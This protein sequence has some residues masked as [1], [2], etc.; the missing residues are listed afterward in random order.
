MR[1]SKFTMTSMNKPLDIFVVLNWELNYV[2]IIYSIYLAG[3]KQPF[4]KQ[5]QKSGERTVSPCS[6]NIV[7]QFRKQLWFAFLILSSAW[8][9]QLK[10]AR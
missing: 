6:I 9:P 4:A 1:N 3:N 10:R 7:S 5:N 8:R 2:I